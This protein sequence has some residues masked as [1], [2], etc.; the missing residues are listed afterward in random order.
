MTLKCYQSRMA[1]GKHFL[2]RKSSTMLAGT[3]TARVLQDVLYPQPTG[4]V[5][6]EEWS[7]G[8]FLILITLWQ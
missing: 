3:T 1:D 6:S 5:K 4:V 2:G 8:R 7:N